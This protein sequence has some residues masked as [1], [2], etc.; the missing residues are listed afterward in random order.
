MPI[1]AEYNH[2]RWIAICPA[3]LAQ[4]MQVAEVVKPGDVFICPIDYPNLY[5]TALMPNPRVPGAFN[6][7]PDQ[8]LREETRQKAIAEGAAQEI[9]FP[10]DWQA[11]ESELRRR[12]VHARNW[13]PGTTLQE[14]KEANEKMVTHA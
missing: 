1:V 3:C 9:I 7:V 6:Q 2:G 8:P 13:Q 4:N 14:I 11:I 12:P 10:Q 5:A